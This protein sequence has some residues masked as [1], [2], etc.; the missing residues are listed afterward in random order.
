QAD[1]A[2]WTAVGRT[3]GRPFRRAVD[4]VGL[5]SYPGTYV[6]GAA[7]IVDYGD[8][9][10]ESLAQMRECYMPKAGLGRRV[11]LRVEETGWP[12]GPGRSAAQQ[13][14][15]L[16]AFVTTA[17]RYRGTYGITAFDWFG[18]RDNNSHGPDYQSYFG[19]LRDDYSAKPAFGAYRQLI[20]RYGA[21]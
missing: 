21:R 20:A 14:R 6:P 4:W 13:R 1:A 19:L 15:V 10:L 9:F 5:D 11:P 8:A 12:T 17:V 3:G 18:L 2:F 16:R 7:A